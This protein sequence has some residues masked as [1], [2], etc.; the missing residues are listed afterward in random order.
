ML[1]YQLCQI[2]GGD[3]KERVQL[4]LEAAHTRSA[5][6]DIYTCIAVIASYIHMHII[7]HVYICERTS[8]G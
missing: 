1:F 4:A 3:D 7:I 8:I 6:F 5:M 2:V